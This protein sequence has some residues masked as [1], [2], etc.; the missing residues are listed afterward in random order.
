MKQTAV[1]W[2]IEQ[3][4][5]TVFYTPEA[6]QNIFEQAKE[7]EKQQKNSYSEEE[8]YEILAQFINDAPNTTKKWFEQIKKNKYGK[9]SF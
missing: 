7:M 5:G 8:V 4:E 3:L 9:V 6:K 2:L 1:E